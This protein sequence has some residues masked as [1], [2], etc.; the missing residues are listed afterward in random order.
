MTLSASLILDAVI[1][2][3]MLAFISTGLRRGFVL[4]ICDLLAVVVG[5]VGG[6]CLSLS[7][8]L[9]GVLQPL[10]EQHVSPELQPVASRVLLFLAGTITVPMLWRFLCRTL[11]LV[12]KLPV[13]H[14]LNK[15]LGGLLGFVKG[16]LVLFLAYWLFCR[17]LGWV[18]MEVVEN[19]ILLPFLAWLPKQVIPGLGG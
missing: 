7:P 2:V 3:M 17:L 10:L 9:M 6:W 1:L 4:S 18:P 8:L 15:T 5:L 19:S 12:T 13:I 14:T 11:R 16:C